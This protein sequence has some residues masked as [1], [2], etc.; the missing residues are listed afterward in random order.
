M[1][2]RREIQGHGEYEKKWKIKE[3]E[4]YIF[5]GRWNE[6]KVVSEKNTRHEKENKKE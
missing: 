5:R 4:K 3:E 2:L 6:E 1:K